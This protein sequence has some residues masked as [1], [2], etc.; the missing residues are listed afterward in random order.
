M[1]N[2][3]T[4]TTFLIID[5]EVSRFSF[6][7]VKD[8]CSFHVVFLNKISKSCADSAARLMSDVVSFQRKRGGAPSPNPLLDDD[9]NDPIANLFTSIGEI[10]TKVL[11]YSFMFSPRVLWLSMS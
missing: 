3:S 11:L 4:S 7:S 1:I 10:R 6:A 5:Y 2:E 9:E 8:E